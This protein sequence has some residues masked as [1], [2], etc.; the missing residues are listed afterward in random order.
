M[1]LKSLNILNFKNH[2]SQEFDFDEKLNAFVGNNAKGKT[3]ILDAIYYLSFTKSFVSTHDTYNVNYDADFFM[4][5]GEYSRLDKNEKISCSFK[6]GQKKQIKRNNLLYKSLSK[7]I[8]LF[9]LVMVSP[10][11]GELVSSGS[12]SRRKWLDGVIS[13]YN[14]QYLEDL[15]LYQNYLKQR[16][17]LLKQYHYNPAELNDL[18]EP[19]NLG[20]IKFGNSIFKKRANFIIDFIPL[21]NDFYASLTNDNQT[22]ALEYHS[23]LK[24]EKIEN[25]LI[26]NFKKDLMLQHS[27][28]GIHKD[29]LVFLLNDNLIKRFGSQGQQKTFLLALKLAQYQHIYKNCSIKPILLL[30]DIF[31]KLDRERVQK[32]IR[33]ILSDHFGQTFIT[34]TNTTRIKESIDSNLQAY[35]I[36]DL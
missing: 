19:Y 11:D 12:E 1:Y 21:F 16:N 35:K 7:H 9:P 33:L 14:K 27:S 32:L 8:G 23:Q 5:N 4:L 10:L 22:V 31:D 20:L 2:L 34:D 29:D 6:K 25:L 26:Q 15:L 13:Q 3:N 30:D 18:L 17:A 36:F 24:E 28:Q